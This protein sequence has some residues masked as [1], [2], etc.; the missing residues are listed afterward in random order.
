[1]KTHIPGTRAPLVDRARAQRGLTLIELMVCCLLALFLFLGYLRVT[2]HYQEEM[3]EIAVRLT[4]SHIQVGMAL[5]W[6][7]RISTNENRRGIEELVGAN[8]VRW[9][10][11]PPYNY[12][13]ELKAPKLEKLEPGRWL[14]DLSRKELVYIVDN[15]DNLV[16]K[17]SFESTKALRWS[18]RLA[19]AESGSGEEK[20]T[21]PEFGE[22]KLVPVHE[23]RWF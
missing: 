4:I 1:M 11:E 18:V 10:D 6:A 20:N 2:R 8:P 23:Y 16:L 13:G 14:F 21:A 15:S 7:R 19:G 17:N 9:L 3:E 5:E 12:L 22:L